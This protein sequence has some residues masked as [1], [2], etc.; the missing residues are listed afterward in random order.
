MKEIDRSEIPTTSFI[1]TERLASLSYCSGFTACSFKVFCTGLV[2]P[3]SVLF[4]AT[5]SSNKKALKIKYTLPAQHQMSDRHRPCLD[6]Q[7]KSVIG[8]IQNDFRKLG[9][10]KEVITN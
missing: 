10:Q 9:Q 2:S 1:S 8:H 6:C 5:V 3:L 4:P 7:P